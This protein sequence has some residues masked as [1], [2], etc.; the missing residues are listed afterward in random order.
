[1]S[2]YSKVS[3]GLKRLVEYWKI[4]RDHYTP[5]ILCRRVLSWKR[6]IEEI[7]QLNRELCSEDSSHKTI[8]NNP[9][10]SDISENIVKFTF[11]VNYGVWLNWNG[12]G[13]LHLPFEI[14]EPTRRG[15]RT[16]KIVLRQIEVKALISDGPSSFGPTESWDWIYFVDMRKFMTENI[17][18]VY[19]CRQS[20]T[21]P[22]IR[23]MSLKNNGETFE[24][25]AMMGRRPRDTFD[26]IRTHLG[27]E[28]KL[29]FSGSLEELLSR[30]PQ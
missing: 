30:V 29:V 12:K 3:C 21:S 22:L 10:P 14:C 8:R 23:T 19:E 11:Y 26:N 7:T 16:K 4:P 1:M 18:S 15:Y 28:C 9:T 6:D 24:T 17:F 27:D 20:N 25:Q 13:D 5:S 2:T